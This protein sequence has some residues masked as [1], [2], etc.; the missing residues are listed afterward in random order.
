MIVISAAIQ[1]FAVSSTRLRADGCVQA[2][3]GLALSAYNT[4]FM[5]LP[6]GFLRRR[7]SG[8]IGA[9]DGKSNPHYQLGNPTDRGL[10]P[11][12]AGQ[13]MYRERP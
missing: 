6:W 11:P 8:R 13:S 4:A 10:Y 7:G 3:R 2:D 12:W 9:G 1:L 5:G